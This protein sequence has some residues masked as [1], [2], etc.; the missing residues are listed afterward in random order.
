MARFFYYGMKNY[1]LIAK[2]LFPD[3]L[4]LPLPTGLKNCLA[5][6]LYNFLTQLKY[7]LLLS[8]KKQPQG[9]QMVLTLQNRV[10]AYTWYTMTGVGPGRIHN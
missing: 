8:K 9:P 6:L 4:N 5:I 3:L 2:N 1:F 10:Y 7:F